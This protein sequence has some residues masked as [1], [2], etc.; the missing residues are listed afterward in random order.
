MESEP[1]ST[2]RLCNS[3]EMKNISSWLSY[4]STNAYYIL[5]L[6]AF[7][8]YCAYRLDIHYH[9]RTIHSN[10]P[11][12]LPDLSVFS[13]GQK[14][15]CCI[16]ATQSSYN[17]EDFQVMR[18]PYLDIPKRAPVF[19]NHQP[20]QP[21]VNFNIILQV[22]QLVGT[23]DVSRGQSISLSLG[24]ANPSGHLCGF[25]KVKNSNSLIDGVKELFFKEVGR[26]SEYACFILRLQTIA[27]CRSCTDFFLVLSDVMEMNFAISRKFV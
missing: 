8:V 21:N 7:E 19:S 1:P 14:Q 23:G 17:A 10:N 25:S 2:F 26:L 22:L 12:K 24:Y 18:T 15:L 13:C 27:S 16:S 5:M 3:K 9:G 6:A 20:S 11:E 4:E